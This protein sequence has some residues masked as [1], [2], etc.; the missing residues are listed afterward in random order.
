MEHIGW[1]VDTGSGLTTADGKTVT[2]FELRH[3]DDD[4]VLSV[5]AQHLRNHYCPDDE[6]DNLRSGTGYSRKEYLVQVKFPDGRA[7]PGP[8]IR[9]GDFGEILVADYLEFV[10]DYWVPRVRYCDKAIRNES[11]KGCDVMGFRI[12]DE[13]R[14]SPRDTLAIYEVKTRFVGNRASNTLQ[15]AVND[16]MKDVTRKAESLNYIK[17]KLLSSHQP[18]GALRVERFQCPEDRPYKE[19][20]GAVALFSRSCYDPRCVSATDASGHPNRGSLTVIAIHG[21][22]MMVLAHDLYRRAADEA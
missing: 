3:A 10:M 2:V 21:R 7:S 8:S 4:E 19:A 14:A 6:I 15:D 22:D 11:S 12:V 20:P 1:L 13:H 16:S 5:W 9:A 17:Q 18:V